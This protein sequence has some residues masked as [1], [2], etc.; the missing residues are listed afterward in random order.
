MKIFFS[1]IIVIASSILCSYSQN[2]VRLEY[3]TT[4]N[5]STRDL[6]G[7]TLSGP[8]LNLNT[9]VVYSNNRV[10][11][12]QVPLYLQEFPDG[13]IQMEIKEKGLSISTPIV[14]D[15]VQMLRYYNLDSLFFIT[16]VD[17]P[18]TALA[19]PNEIRN[20]YFRFE[21]GFERWD[22]LSDSMI[23]EGKWCKRAQMRYSHNNEILYDFWYTEEIPIPLGPMGYVE[24]PGLVIKGTMPPLGY[25]FELAKY[26]LQANIL[27]Q[28]LWKKELNERFIKKAFLPSSRKSSK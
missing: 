14:M 11:S 1:L 10:L 19:N 8:T 4:H 3:T 28:E 2:G 6:Q 23:I 25:S 9:K 27:P 5:Y 15:S 12:Y 13:M 21:H 20:Q 18:K 22:L 17:N 26:D 7:N 16:R 24:L